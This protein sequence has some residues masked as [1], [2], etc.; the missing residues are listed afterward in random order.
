MESYWRLFNE[1]HAEVT[2]QADP[3]LP[4]LSSD[5]FSEVEEAYINHGSAID[6]WIEARPAPIP[7]MSTSN[8]AEPDVALPPMKL[9]SFSG[10][11]YQWES[12]RDQF[13]ALVHDST[14]IP[15]VRKMQ[16]LKSCL[17]GVAAKMLDLTP[18]TEGSYDG[19]WTALERRFGNQRSLTLAHMRRLISYPTSAKAEPSEIKRL[20]DAFRQNQRTFQALKKPV[21]EWDEWLVFLASEKQDDEIG[22]GGLAEGS[23]SHPVV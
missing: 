14:R 19:A 13:C 6:E 20:L 16:Y 21:K 9:P 1:R 22:V 11:P 7:I 23:N 8:P 10:D 17:S 12:F 5:Y 2:L 4:Y 15:K 3:E 18:I